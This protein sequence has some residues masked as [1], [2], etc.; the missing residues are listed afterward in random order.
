L[1]APIAARYKQL[2][3][4]ST[5][6]KI[7]KRVGLSY[8]SLSSLSENLSNIEKGYVD[9]LGE[10]AN[11]LM[12]QIKDVIEEGYD[13]LELIYFV[14]YIVTDFFQTSGLTEQVYWKIVNEFL[15]NYLFYEVT[16]KFG[17]TSENLTADLNN[18][19]V[20]GA[21]RMN[22]YKNS[23]PFSQGIHDQ[24]MALIGELIKDFIQNLYPDGRS[25]SHIR[26]DLRI[27][28]MEYAAYH[29]RHRTLLLQ[30]MGDN[31]ISSVESLNSRNKGCFVATYIYR[32]YETT[33][34]R[35]LRNFKDI[36]LN[37]NSFGRIIIKIYYF[38][39]PYL[40]IIIKHIPFSRTLI[41]GFLDQFL[42]L[43]KRRY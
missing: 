26:G 18:Y 38:I 41:K 23:F 36:V 12:I 37:N 20:R 25:A 15:K 19:S 6:N 32:G 34:V 31:I 11:E 43:I 39:G 27:I 1:K 2:I 35:H 33:Q 8:I 22:E 42:H 17:P 40:V 30:E 9:F 24:D 28:L 3:I 5:T 16:S 21:N 4:Y 14:E 29:I 13:E 10:S 7:Q